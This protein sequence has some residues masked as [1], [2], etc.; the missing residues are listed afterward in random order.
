MLKNYLHLS[1]KDKRIME[2]KTLLE[3]IKRVILYP[4]L[5]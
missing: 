1:G 2:I 4:L 3:I 5:F